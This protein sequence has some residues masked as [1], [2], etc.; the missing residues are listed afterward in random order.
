VRGPHGVGKSSPASEI[1][2]ILKDLIGAQANDAD[3]LS[4]MGMSPIPYSEKSGR[5]TM[6]HTVAPSEMSWLSRC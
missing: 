6:K 4:S 3:D 2:G 5:L 1:F